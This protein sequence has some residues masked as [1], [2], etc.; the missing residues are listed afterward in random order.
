MRICIIGHPRSRSTYLL[1][2]IADYFKIPEIPHHQIKNVYNVLPVEC[3]HSSQWEPI[4]DP[5]FP[6]SIKEEFLIKFNEFQSKIKNKASFI[7][8]VH[9]SQ[10]AYFPASGQLI[11]FDLFGFQQYNQIYF[12]VRK[13]HIDA[14]CSYFIANKTDK[15]HYGRGDK[16]M[17]IEAQPMSNNIAVMIYIWHDLISQELK[18]YLDNK[19]IAWSEIYYEDMT[20][21]VKSNYPTGLAN[22]IETG[23][24]YKQLITNYDELTDTYNILK[25]KVTA[26]FYEHNPDLKNV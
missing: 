7:I 25:D 24:D 3:Y 19:N 12:T 13:N 22:T 15:W 17:S 11:D 2:V 14:I 20:D 16:P 5:N 21:Y 10:L 4:W 9:P 18:K 8:K 26:L 1:N 23:Y 6:T